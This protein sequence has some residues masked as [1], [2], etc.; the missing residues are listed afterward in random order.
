MIRTS[1]I[2]LISVLGGIAVLP[3][4]SV[5]EGIEAGPME[6]LLG[7]SITYGIAVGPRQDRKVF[8]L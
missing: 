7:L 6:Q 3:G 8:T 4:A 5:E 1:P 2:Q